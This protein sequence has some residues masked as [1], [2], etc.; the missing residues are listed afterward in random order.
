MEFLRRNP[1]Y[2]EAESETPPAAAEPAPFPIRVHTWADLH[3]APAPG[4]RS[5]AE[6][7]DAPGWCLSGLRLAD[8]GTVLKVEHG[9]A[10]VQ[11]IIEEEF[12]PEA[13]I[14]LR[15][16]AR[17]LDLH[18]PLLDAAALS[19]TVAAAPRKKQT[20]HPRRR[21]SRGARRPGRRP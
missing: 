2:M 9:G 21:A 7:L 13:G 18:T 8:G 1:G 12:D 20:P 15:V 3:A 4:A 16:P 6:V 14:E 17:Q 19:P 5:L 10:A 11:L